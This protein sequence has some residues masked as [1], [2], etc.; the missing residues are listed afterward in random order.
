MGDSLPEVMPA[1]TVAVCAAESTVTTS[2]SSLTERKRSLLS[3]MVLK[4]CLVPRTFRRLCFLTKSRTSSTE[5]DDWRRSVLYSILPAQFVILPAPAQ[6]IIGATKR[7]PITA[8]DSRRKVLLFIIR[9]SLKCVGCNHGTPSA[10]P[11]H[12]DQVM[13]QE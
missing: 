2:F 3:A 13:L 9:V 7:L 6:A 8:A 4:Q 12:P 11:S 10:S 5:A 1:S